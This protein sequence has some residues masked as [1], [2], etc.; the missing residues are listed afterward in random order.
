MRRQGLSGIIR[1]VL[2]GGIGLLALASGALAL[3]TKTQGLPQIWY[4]GSP[5]P[6]RELMKW[7]ANDYWRMFQPS[8]EPEWAQVARRMDV[9]LLALHGLRIPSDENLRLLF[10]ALKRHG[11]KLAVTHGMVEHEP[12]CGGGEG[13]A[14]DAVMHPR[15]AE[16]IKRLG[17]TIDYVSM[18]EP[19]IRAHKLKQLGAG[20]VGCQYPIR[21]VARRVK[22]NVM[23]IRAVFPEVRIGSTEAINT[24]ITGAG[25]QWA[26]SIREWS[27][28]F[29]L[30]TGKPLAFSLVAIN[31]REPGWEPALMA[32]SRHAQ[33]MGIPMGVIYTGAGGTSDEA[34]TRI[35]ID[36]FTAVE[37]NAGLRPQVTAIMSWHQWPNFNLPEDKP[38]T[39]TNV[40]LR[41]LHFRGVRD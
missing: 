8:A 1:A 25:P 5:P 28:A 32:W 30:E 4:A 22:A 9:F 37:K 18:D 40:L 23:G 10:A 33:R 17:G 35:A 39:L 24:A 3:D 2:L 36:N 12:T 11:I 26:E 34:W 21:E 15:Q 29:H 16:R 31:W 27:E 41:Y 13:Y 20:R 14:P 38:G 7:P 19:L 6:I